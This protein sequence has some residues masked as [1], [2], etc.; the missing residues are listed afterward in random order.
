MGTVLTLLRELFEISMAII[1]AYTFIILL[2]TYSIFFLSFL[3]TAG[4]LV[5][6]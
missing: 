6:S 3:I 4:T 2:P 1:A 5:K